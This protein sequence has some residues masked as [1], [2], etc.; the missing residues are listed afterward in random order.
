MSDLPLLAGGQSRLGLNLTPEQLAQL[1][2]Y[3]EML[4]DWNSRINLTSITDYEGVQVRH[5]LDSFTVGAALLAELPQAGV[6]NAA[7]PVA[8]YRLVDIGTGAGFPGV[9]L[10]ILWPQIHLTLAESVG[11]RTAFL[12]ALI[13][14]L[15]L[16]NVEI[17]TARAEALGQDKAHREQYDAVTARAVAAL[18]VLCEY[19]LPLVKVGGLMLAPKKGD[20]SPEIEGAKKAGP[21]LG[22]EAPRLHSFVLPGE[23]EERYVVTMSKIKS[24]PSGYPRRVGLAKSRPLG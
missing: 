8:G 3:Y 9:P 7:V 18:P 12:K 10:K 1:Q 23:N 15:G 5:F 2:T 17:I 21:I 22:G 11:K 20:I 14:E 13:A 16:E 24:T 6:G 4:V 19:S